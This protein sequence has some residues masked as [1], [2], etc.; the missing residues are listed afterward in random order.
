[1]DALLLLYDRPN[2]MPRTV[3]HLLI[4]AVYHTPQKADKTGVT[5]C[6]TDTV[7]VTRSHATALRCPL[8]PFVHLGNLIMKGS[9]S[10][11]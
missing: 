9:R 1:V 7:E 6:L 2:C 8:R 10:N 5:E 3:I 11:R 4:S